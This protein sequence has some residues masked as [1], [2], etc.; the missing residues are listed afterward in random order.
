MIHLTIDGQAVEH[1]Q[2]ITILE[3]AKKLG[4][5]IPTLCYNEYIKPYGGCRLCLVEI[6]LETVPERTRLM[7]SCCTT[8]AEGQIVQTATESVLKAQR[9]MI[10]LYLA[11]SPKSEQLQKIARDLG[12]PEN[13]EELDPVGRYLLTRTTPPSDTSCILCGLCV[14]VCAEIT[15]RHALSFELRGIERKVSTPFNRYA[16]TCIGCQSCAYVCPTGAIT[17][18]EID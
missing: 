15:E 1:E 9:F 13:R 7:P 16:E 18:E 6:A 3:A 5:K 12:I 14:R 4:I 2:P 11:R 8:I 17:V 10:E